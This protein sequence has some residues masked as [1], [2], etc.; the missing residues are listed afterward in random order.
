MSNKQ[1]HPPE[2]A[3]PSRNVAARRRV[4]TLVLAVAVAVPLLGLAGYGYF[5]YIRRVADANE[6]IDHLARVAQEHALKV[7]DLNRE[8]SL[9]VLDMLNDTDDAQLRAHQ[10]SVHSKL[11]TIASDFPQVAA[12]SVFGVDGKLLANSNYFPVPVVA[13]PDGDHFFAM[14][15]APRFH[16]S[17]PS[18]GDVS[19][20]NVFETNVGRFG[21]DGA[22]LGIVSIALRREYFADFYRELVG[23]NPALVLGLEREDGS[24]LVRYPAAP[25]GAPGASPPKQ[26]SVARA[27]QQSLRA[28]HAR[29]R[30]TVDG[31]ERLF[32]FKQVG[33]FPLYAVS[34]YPTAVVF[35][36]WWHHY[37]L[38]ATV[39][40]LPCIGIWVLVLF[41][42]RQIDT[43]QAAWES[44]R[45]EVTARTLAEESARQ[46]QRMGAIGN[47]VSSVAHDFNNLLMVISANLEIVRRKRYNNVEHE[48]LTMKRAM[49]NAESL[50]R[51]L[52]SVARKQPLREQPVEFRAWLPAVAG[53]LNTSLGSHVSLDVDVAPDV[54][55]VCIDPTELEVAII[56]IAVNARDAMPHGGH[57]TIRCRNAALPVTDANVSPGEYVELSCT[58]DGEGMTEAVAR[59]A[60]EPLFTTKPR[61]SGTGLG[62]AQVLATCEQAG[63]AARI[64]SVHGCG[65]TVF[66]YLPRYQS[67]A[68]PTLP[69]EPPTGQA[70]MGIPQSTVLLV[71]DNAEVAAGIAAVLEVFGCHVHH[72]TSAD[73]A[74][75]VL[76]SGKSFDV[77]LSDVHMPGRLNGI[78]LAERVRHRWPAQKIA[79]MTGYAEELE[80]AERL[81]VPILAKPFRMEELSA[82][83]SAQPP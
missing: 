76:D 16:I 22:F 4:L 49:E 34:G 44:W 80:R 17:L 9:R 29:T 30:S 31:A 2:A 32:A 75:H 41:S 65:T 55:N 21:V 60:F 50:T 10:S 57:F 58:D 71:E 37:A 3:L 66:L 36:A 15:T 54:W 24:I 20:K 42:L 8:M 63:G 5:D 81:D 79:L 14:R 74:L 13:F 26:A 77:I 67:R 82:L 47:L 39:T 70:G 40:L 35:E 61:G 1:S 48:A 69:S 56:N 46:S 27:L 73:T 64:E 19:Q 43:E 59:R 18:L 45:M 83:V 7:L 53:I 68:E 72:E 23:D 28:G 12:I 6:T 78:D 33:S 52:L 38:A 25:P 62:L 51:R 11:K